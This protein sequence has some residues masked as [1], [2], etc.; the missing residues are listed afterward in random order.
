LSMAVICL[1]V[2]FLF[3]RLAIAHVLSRDSFGL[4][5]P[6]PFRSSPLQRT[7]PA[8][9]F[10]PRSL[11]WRIANSRLARRRSH[12]SRWCQDG[13]CEP[14]HRS[15]L[16]RPLRQCAS[17]ACR[18]SCAGRASCRSRCCASRTLRPCAPVA[19]VAPVE[20]CGPCDPVAPLHRLHQSRPSPLRA[21]RTG[22]HQLHRRALLPLHTTVVDVTST[23]QVCR[24]RSG[25]A[26]AMLEPPAL[27]WL[28]AHRAR[29][30]RRSR[31]FRLVW[32][33]VLVLAR[34]T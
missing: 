29:S 7:P 33:Q 15:R 26:N 5:Y 16:L 13:P 19:P 34:K 10:A 18:A 1:L 32:T 20:P 22:S 12:W 28:P 4:K 25:P 8:G 6:S 21:R 14:V 30:R 9:Q 17:C 3:S 27:H 2:F 23:G 24:C 31:P 11:S